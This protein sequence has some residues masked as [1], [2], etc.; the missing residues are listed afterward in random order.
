MVKVSPSKTPMEISLAILEAPALYEEEQYAECL[1]QVNVNEL[2]HIHQ[3]ITTKGNE[4]IDRMTR[5]VLERKELLKNTV[6]K[7]EKW[8]DYSGVAGCAG[9]GGFILTEGTVAKVCIVAGVAFITFYVLG[10]AYAEY[11]TSDEAQR[12]KL[13]YIF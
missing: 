5:N 7:Y 8:I 3:T 6:A 2:E 4:I 12:E 13:N 1:K 10:K 11:I 9:L